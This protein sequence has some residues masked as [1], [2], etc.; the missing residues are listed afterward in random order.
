MLETGGLDWDLCTDLLL[1]NILLWVVDQLSLY[2]NILNT[3]NNA[4]LWDIL[5]IAV[6]VGLWNI[7]SDVLNGHIVSDLLLLWDVLHSLDLL[8]LNDSLLIWNILDPR[9]SLDG[10]PKTSITSGCANELRCGKG[11]I[12]LL[13]CNLASSNLLAPLFGGLRSS[14][15][16][17][18]LS[19]L[20]GDLRSSLD[21]ALLALL[22]PLST[23]SV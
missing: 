15:Y 4:F 3:F 11:L 17:A 20:S 10:F 7:L 2:W 14:L 8:I 23:S 22:A 21:K 12:Y 9:F 18:L 6:L 19:P 13:A 1:F 16:K 5:N